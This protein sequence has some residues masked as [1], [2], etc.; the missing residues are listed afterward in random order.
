MIEMVQFLRPDWRRTRPCVYTGPIEPELAEHA[1]QFA[2]AGGTLFL[3]FISDDQVMF[4]A[5]LAGKVLVSA[6]AEN[7]EAGTTSAMGCLL[8]IVGAILHERAMPPTTDTLQ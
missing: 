2:A 7:S 3:A 8:E 5:C 4:G 6:M 1:R